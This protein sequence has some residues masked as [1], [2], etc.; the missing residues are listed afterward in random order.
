MESIRIPFFIEMAEEQKTTVIQQE[1]LTPIQP[2]ET[3]QTIRNSKPAK[4]KTTYQTLNDGVWFITA[5]LQILL[6]LRIVFKLLNTEI[7]GFVSFVY[8]A[9]DYVVQPFQGIFSTASSG[10]SYFDSPAVFAMVILGLVLWAVNSIVNVLD[11]R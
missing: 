3:Q 4:R 1:T 11:N 2:V 6:A 5:V 7:S 10:E 9:S 8:N